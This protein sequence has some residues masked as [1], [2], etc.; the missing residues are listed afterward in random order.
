MSATDLWRI[1]LK[2]AVSLLG[3]GLFYSAWLALFLLVDPLNVAVLDAA[4]WLLA[5]VITAAGFA[6]G[7]LASARLTGGRR[8]P[9]L[10]AM[11][12]P[13]VGCALGALAVYW[14]GPMLIVFAM[15]W[16]GTLSVA[17]REFIAP[18]R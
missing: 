4:L 5:P 16:A 2:S 7:V 14:V 17:L 15:L 9:F 12:W 10:R 13:L 6:A 3:G 1:G 18:R 8:E 11:A